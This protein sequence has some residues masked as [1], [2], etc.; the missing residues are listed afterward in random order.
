MVKFFKIKNKSRN[1]INTPNQHNKMATQ[2]VKCDSLTKAGYPCSKYAIPGEQYCKAHKP[3]DVNERCTAITK[4]GEPCKLPRS[5]GC[6]VCHV[7]GGIPVSSEE[8]QAAETDPEFAEITRRIAAHETE[9]RRLKM[10]KE[11]LKKNSKEAKEAKLKFYH[12]MKGDLS[13]NSTLKERIAAL[14][15]MKKDKIPW[16]IIKGI[17]DTM[18]ENLN[19]EEKQVWINISKQQTPV[20]KIKPPTPT[21]TTSTNDS[22]QTNNMEE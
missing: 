9:L 14:G 22:P 21:L 5:K 20:K 8:E 13:N 11:R 3:K 4:K 15:V 19:D 2:R 10:E 16:E 18:F 12:H 17:T 1:Q 7:H 6:M